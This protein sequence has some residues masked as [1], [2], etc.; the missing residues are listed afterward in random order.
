MV[1]IMIGEIAPGKGLLEG[2]TTHLISFV[3]IFQTP[4]SAKIGQKLHNGVVLLGAGTE[5]ERFSV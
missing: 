2:V 4:L 3:R 5:I 1:S